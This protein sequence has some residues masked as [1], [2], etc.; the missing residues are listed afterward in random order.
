MY[1]SG[2]PQAHQ[3]IVERKIAN[4]LVN[5]K[6]DDQLQTVMEIVNFIA[7]DPLIT[8][9]SRLILSL[10]KVMNCHRKNNERLPLFVSRFHGLASEHLMIADESP[11]STVGEVLA[12]TLLNN[13][14]LP[15]STLINAKSELIKMA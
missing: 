12:I 7:Y 1:E 9:V 2:F 5:L 14:N 11:S 3:S 13:A 4:G 10:N 8:V 6:Q 15:Q